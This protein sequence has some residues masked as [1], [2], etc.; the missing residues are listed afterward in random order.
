MNAR[1]GGVPQGRRLLNVHN[2]TVYSNCRVCIVVQLPPRGK[3]TAN[4]RLYRVAVIGEGSTG[5]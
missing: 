4:D 3:P 2:A 1:L 5:C